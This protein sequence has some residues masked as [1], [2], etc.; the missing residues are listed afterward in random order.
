MGANAVT[1]VPSYVSGDV[2]TAANLNITNSGVPVFATTTTRDAAF[3][4]TGEKTLAQ[5]QLAFIEASNIVQY[6]NGTSWLTLAPTTSGATFVAGAA[7]SAAG[8]TSVNN[9]FTSSYRNYLLVYEVEPSTTLTLTMRLRASGTDDSSSNYFLGA[10]A[11]TNDAS[12]TTWSN[13]G[14]TSWT[15]GYASTAVLARRIRGSLT[16]YAPQVAVRTGISGTITTARATN[17]GIGGGF[18]GGDFAGTTQFD[19][20][21]LI[22]STGNVT[23][24]YRVYGLADS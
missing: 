8:T 6:Y 22:A 4:G 7:I 10:E 1:T 5:G 17:V 14:A 9:C 23:G 24:S 2:L 16:I 21:S 12:D 15:L 13:D 3:G 20:F 19:G 11:R 18:L